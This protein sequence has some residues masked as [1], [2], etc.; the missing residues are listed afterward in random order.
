MCRERL[1]GRRWAG[2]PLSGAEQRVAGGDPV[3]SDV[4]LKGGVRGRARALC[5]PFAAERW[6]KPHRQSP[7]LVF[8]PRPDRSLHQTRVFALSW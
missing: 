2:H 4:M 6:G 7:V 8:L 3:S 1:A 5:G